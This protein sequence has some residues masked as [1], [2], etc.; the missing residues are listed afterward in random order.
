M[1]NNPAKYEVLITQ[2]L[3]SILDISELCSGHEFSS[4]DYDGRFCILSLMAWLWELCGNFFSL[5]WFSGAP[6]DMETIPQ[7]FARV[8]K[9]HNWVDQGEMKALLN[10]LFKKEIRVVKVFKELLEDIVG[11][12]QLSMAMRKDLQEELKCM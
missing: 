7:F 1:P 9:K 3:R 8:G 11:G 12:L 2:Y 6:S 4:L 5:L 10:N